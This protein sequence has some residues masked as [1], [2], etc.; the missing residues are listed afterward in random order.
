MNRLKMSSAV[1]TKQDYYPDHRDPAW[2]LIEAQRHE[3][4]VEALIQAGVLKR[5]PEEAK[6]P[7]PWL[8]LILAIIVLVGAGVAGADDRNHKE[9]EY[10]NGR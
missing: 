8:L 10:R 9:M 4:R 5:A 7:L 6:Q 3:N 1:F 2:K